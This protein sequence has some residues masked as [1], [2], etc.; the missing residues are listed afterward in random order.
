MA[1]TQRPSWRALTTSLA[2]SLPNPHP[3]AFWYLSTYWV[4]CPCQAPCKQPV[5]NKYGDYFKLFI[6]YWERET[7]QILLQIQNK[8]MLLINAKEKR[9]VVLLRHLMALA[10]SRASG[11]A[12][13]REWPRGCACGKCGVCS[14]CVKGVGATRAFSCIHAFAHIA[15]CTRHPSQ[16]QLS[17]HLLRRPS[18]IAQV[19]SDDVLCAHMVLCT[20]LP[21]S[22]HLM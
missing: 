9:Y 11:K 1:A 4:M 3:P 18:L 6:V 22:G 2:S 13:L 17:C 20:C 12:F 10:S 7:N 16:M 19:R 8:M 14:R 15:L 21:L 5:K